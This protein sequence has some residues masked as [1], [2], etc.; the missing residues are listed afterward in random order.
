MAVRKTGQDKKKERHATCNNCGAK[1]AFYQQDIKSEALYSYG[2]YDGCYWYIICP[3]CK[4]RVIV[5]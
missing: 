2:E 4:S 3:E 5:K 1:L